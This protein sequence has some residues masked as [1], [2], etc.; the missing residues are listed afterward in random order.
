MTLRLL[1]V[2]AAA[3]LSS[4]T[5]LADAATAAEIAHLVAPK[6]GWSAW[7]DALAQGAQAQLTQHPGQRLEFPADFQKTARAE[8][9]KAF[10]YEE[11]VAFSAK[12]ISAAYS[13]AE[14][15][16]VLGFFK[17]P[18]G[19]KWLKTS[20]DTAG[21]ANAAM[22]QQL[23]QRMP[24]IMMKLAKLGKPDGK[25]PPA[26]M[27]GMPAGHPAMGGEKKAAPA[28]KADPA[29]AKK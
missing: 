8:I 4:S 9:E 5:A 18:V 2:A 11:M 14:Q 24:D 1:A 7:V 28:K 12:E 23:Q 22:E 3:L 19:Q 26:G 20:S 10:P 16:E 13:D 29:P 25:A 15:K 6:A 27:G 21:K 17:S